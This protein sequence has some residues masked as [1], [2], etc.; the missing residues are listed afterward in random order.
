MGGILVARLQMGEYDPR[1]A[2]HKNLY[3]ALED[4]ASPI[5]NW[6]SVSAEQTTLTKLKFETKTFAD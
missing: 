4:R 6:L 2:A 5:R 3:R 1:A